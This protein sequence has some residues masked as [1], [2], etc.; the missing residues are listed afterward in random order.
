MK[1][2]LHHISAYYAHDLKVQY[3]DDE[4]GRM[5]VC[6]IAELR[7]D[8]CTIHD[9]ENQ[10]EVEF[11]EFMPILRPLSDLHNNNLHWKEASNNEV[12]CNNDEYMIYKDFTQNKFISHPFWQW[13]VE[14]HFDVFNLI[15]NRC[16][17]DINTTPNN[18][19]H[20][21][22]KKRNENYSQQINIT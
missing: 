20:N 21:K 1:L 16:A 22:T 19:V 14:N 17:I 2:E 18:R 15:P 3:Y 11:Y 8:E 10:W 9:D 12:C 5:T 4:R 6:E 7:K 13:L